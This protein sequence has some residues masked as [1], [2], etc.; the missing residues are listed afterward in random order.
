MK[1]LVTLLILSLFTNHIYSQLVNYQVEIIAVERT[2]YTDCAGCGSPD[3]TWII[4]LDDNAS[5]TIDNVGIHVP[6]N[7]TIYTPVNYPLSNRINSSATNFVLG[8]DAWEDNCN[9]DV[10]NFNPY[11]FFTC[12]PSV[13]GDSRR[14]QSNNVAAVNFRT[15]APCIWQMG[16]AS[17]CGD[18]RFTYRFKWSFNQ[19]PVIATQPTPASSNLCLG[20]PVTFS[21]TPGVDSNGWSLGTNYQWQ[22][23]SITACA[24]ATAASWSNV[25]G[26]NSNTFTAP[27]IPGTRLYRCLVT[28]NCTSTFTS[29]TT[30]SN[31]VRVTYNPYGVPGDLPP[32]VQS[33]ICG[34]VVLPGSTHPLT[35]LLPPAVGAA[36]GVTFVW[37]TTGGTFSQ[38]TGSSTIWTAPSTAGNYT[39]TLT[40]VD[41]C[42]NPN[43]FTTCVVD[44]GSPN[45]DFAYVA[46]SGIDD[47][48]AGGPNNPYRTLAYAISQLSSRKYIR[49]AGG[50]YNES[51][52]IQ[53]QNDLIIE[54]G[55]QFNAGIWIKSTTQIT[56]LVL[57][58]FE[59]STLTGN[60]SA[61]H[62]VGILG[63]NDD[64]FTLQDLTISTTNVSGTTP[65]NSGRSNYAVLLINGCDDYNIVRCSI[66]SGTASRGA[67]GSILAAG[68]GATGGTGGGIG[69]SGSNGS[70]NP[71]GGSTGATGQNAGYNASIHPGYIFPA[72]ADG[73]GGA[74]GAGTDNCGG[75]PGCGF[76]GPSDGGCNGNSG[77]SGSIGSTG[78]YWQVN[79]RPIIP[80]A[81]LPYYIPGAQAGSGQDGGG[82]GRGAG[83][84]GS[85]GGQSAPL[86]IDC[87]GRTGGNAGNGGT[88]GRG[89][90]G[91]YGAGGSFSI[92]T[93]NSSVGANITNISLT[94]PISPALGGT[95][96]NGSSG[97]GGT[98]GSGGSCN[99][100]V[101]PGVRCSGAGGTGAFG[102]AGGRGRD[103]SNGAIAHLVID[104]VASNPSTSIPNFPIV[105]VEYNNAK[106]C[107]NSEI[108]LTKDGPN[109]WSL[110]LPFV[111][112]LSNSPAPLVTSSFSNGSPEVQVYST[113]PG[114]IVNLQVGGSIFNGFLRIANDNRVLPVLTVSPSNVNCI[115]S[116][117]NTSAS[118]WGTEVEYDWRIYVGT[119]VDNPSLSP[120]TLASPSFNLTGLTPGLYT[121]R[122]RVREVCCGW[123][124]PVYDTIRVIDK[125]IVYQV[126]GGGGYCAGSAGASIDLSGSQS[127]VI[128]ELLLNG[129]PVDT[130]I[131]TGAPFSFSPQLIPGNYTVL[132]YSIVACDRMMQ[133]SV[134]VFVHPQ[135]NDQN[136]IGDSYLCAQGANTSSVISLDNSQIGVN[137]QLFLNNTI[138]LGVPIAGNGFAISFG[139]QSLSGQYTVLA[140]NN[141]T[142]CSR[143]LSDTLTIV[144]IPGPTPYTMLGG[145]S[146]CA[147]TAGVPI[148]LSNSDSNVDY[149]L[150]WNFT[151]PIGPIV[152]GSGLPLA[153]EN[154]SL[155]GNYTIIATDDLGCQTTMLDTLGVD[156]LNPPTFQ[157]VLVNGLDC[158][159]DSTASITINANSFNGTL[160][161]VLNLD[162]NTS[163]IFNNLAAG[164]YLLT[165]VDDSLCSN[166]YP[167]TPINIPQPAPLVIGLESVQDVLCFGQNQGAIGVNVIG[168]TA[169][170]NYAWSSSNA[171]YTS[172]NEDIS[173]LAG[174]AYYLNV[175]DQK[176]CTANDTFAV[177][178]PVAV[179][180]GVITTLDLLC[181]GTNSGSATITPSGGTA[182]YSY[183]WHTNDTAQTI[184]GLSPG[185]VSVTITDAN[186]CKRYVSSTVQGP[187]AALTV[188]LIRI[189]NVSCFGG[190][191]GEILTGISGGTA[192]YTV[193]WT[194]TGDTT[195]TISNLIAGSYTITVTDVNGCV[196]S[197][198][199]NITQ[200]LQIVT[201]IA[202]TQPGCP[203]EQTGIASV[204][205]NG[206]VA[207]YSYVW[208]TTPNQFGIVASQLFGDR[209]YT[210]T[211]T[212]YNA[213]IVVDSVFIQ[214]PDTMTVDVLPGNTSCI[215][216]N[217]G[218]A[219]IEV[220]GGSAPFSYE[221][222]GN[223]QTDSAFTNLTPGNYF[224]FVED[225][226]GCVASSQFTITPTTSL[227]VQLLGSSLSDFNV[228]DEIIVVSEE[229]IQLNVNLLNSTASTQV[230][231]YYWT[232]LAEMDFANCAVDTLCDNPTLGV[233][234]NIQVVVEVVEIVNG[235][236]CSVFDTLKIKVRTDFP[237][238]FP[239][240][241]SPYSGEFKIECLN[242]YFEVNV[243]G[244]NNLDVK[245]F[246]RWGEMVFSNPTQTNGP[247]NPNTLDCTNPRNAWDGTFNGT[248]VP[249]GAYIYQVIATYFNG[250]T[251]TYSGTISVLR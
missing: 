195:L 12:F 231:A 139:P 115:G 44:V 249:I 176:G 170:Y 41:A 201:A 105:T 69:G 198:T 104:G 56:N 54:G 208:S 49:M 194:P 40:Y 210:V 142:T 190:N 238:F 130:V 165:I 36:N 22:V 14:C 180:S 215:S 38:N 218:F 119:D 43:A 111:N 247:S 8:L 51:S 228:A 155:E 30:A 108:N 138:P 39:I 175:V 74:G 229:P 106:A 128:Y 243:A 237:V 177:N 212:D 178:A 107:I 110:P 183:L 145:G 196:A 250:D 184:I 34:S 143:Y 28:S 207:P 75:G 127:G 13:Y 116:T 192:P 242:D 124:I 151:V 214:N 157:T 206:G 64:R 63:D 235:V 70:G 45:C 117:V 173:G 16:T 98:A 221:L 199:F 245:V 149:Q 113:T 109:S 72:G 2:N 76:F 193:V 73:S 171:G 233:S 182:P 134:N 129:G 123:S 96:A 148:D 27:Q 10:F 240:A 185:A 248:P 204:G 147:G 168:G 152:N 17:F 181:N 244:A 227:D 217:D 86:C 97:T 140:V 144:L 50:T 135:P 160:S 26:A 163:G 65:S 122:Y 137:Y 6:G 225:N 189:T 100:C 80:I 112:D 101:L 216:G 200:P 136:I 187:L 37:A 126:S 53:L 3:P 174:G 46:T 59:N 29:N 35:A 20:T 1:K 191:D 166:I 67:D 66:N 121:L 118:S 60:P 172:S 159:G 94:I 82:G 197:R 114:Q 224:I 150:V 251:K 131:G 90:T 223:Y 84:N 81:N 102:G 85:R 58:G 246:N 32:V 93:N 62:R 89:G 83:G 167:V 179:L 91:G 77:S 5:T 241:F 141:A 23:S 87:D 21:I 48:F 164:N 55:Y 209:W 205:A 188:E 230:I 239:T 61:E 226:K 19:A 103:G 18:Y 132:A 161:Y 186:G 33:G 4:D 95:G 68:G 79:D 222:N 52:I 220:T 25:G 232:P 7:G 120:S 99:G 15:F 47:V 42:S 9:N 213:C 57:S 88:G 211:V 78:R 31:C 133:G 11:N 219:Y 236:G 154:H 153:F 203:G 146:F 169:L 234:Q 24:S 156:E 202:P 158:F 71:G 162:T 92:Y 125:P